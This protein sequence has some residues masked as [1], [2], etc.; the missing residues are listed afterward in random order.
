MIK[1]KELIYC[2]CC[3]KYKEQSVEEWFTISY[4]DFKKLGLSNYTR[5]YTGWNTCI[6]TS[7]NPITFKRKE[8]CCFDCFVKYFKEKYYDNK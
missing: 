3:E 1:Y 2:D 6:S 5:E 7:L 8:F 4:S